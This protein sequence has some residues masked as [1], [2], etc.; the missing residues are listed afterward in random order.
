MQ[1]ATVSPP[2][3]FRILGDETRLAVVRMLRLTD[4]TV[5]QIGQRLHLPQNAVSYHLR[6][7][8]EAGLLRARRSSHDSRDHYY[9]LAHGALHAAWRTA[10][11]AV[12]HGGLTLGATAP[13]RGMRVLFVCTHNSARSQLA[14]ALLR[15]SAGTWAEAASAGTRPAGLHPETARLLAELGADPARHWSKPLDAV[16]GPFDLAVTVCDTAR[17]ECPVADLA[18]RWLHWSLP[19]P[20]SAPPDAQREAFRAVFAELQERVSAL[21]PALGKDSAPAPE[22]RR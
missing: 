17:E 1:P 3:F 21:V 19:D 10:E 9:A 5:A 6:L 2:T 16:A 22:A 7:L 13:A 8:R 11:A 20:L 18:P 4:M 15:Q 14:E 12:L